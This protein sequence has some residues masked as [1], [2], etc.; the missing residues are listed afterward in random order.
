MERRFVSQS[1]RSSITISDGNI[2]SNIDPYS[3]LNRSD[4]C[5]AEMPDYNYKIN[6]ANSHRPVYET[7]GVSAV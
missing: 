1:N 4:R 7:C 6:V 2:S 3:R 5:S